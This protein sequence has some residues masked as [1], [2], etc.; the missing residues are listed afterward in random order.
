[1]GDVYLALDTRLSRR[2]ALKFLPS[3]LTSDRAML[4]RFEQEART[5]SALNHPNIL[6]IY[7]IGEVAGNTSSPANTSTESLCARPSSAGPLDPATILDIAIQVASALAAAHAA[8]IVHRDL[9]PGNIMLRPDGYVKVIDFGLAK[10]ALRLGPG[11]LASSG[12]SRVR[13]SAPLT[14]CR[15]NKRA[16]KRSTIAPISG[17]SAW[18]ST[19]WRRGSVPSKEKRKAMCWSP[20]SSAPRSPYR[21]SARPLPAG[22][23]GIITRALSK[24]RAK[25]YQT[26]REMLVDLQQVAQASGLASSIRPVALPPSATT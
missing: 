16:E 25:R 5:A 8:G 13:S 24:D 12:R 26:A 10:R 7:E 14:T 17:V 20:F 21:C 15:L 6:T 19:K 1:M 9:K 11:C 3:D 22:L 4:A 23:S 18:C 2:V